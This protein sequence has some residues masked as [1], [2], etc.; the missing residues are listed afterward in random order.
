MEL[1]ISRVISSTLALIF[2]DNLRSCSIIGSTFVPANM[3]TML[4]FFPFALLLV[5]IV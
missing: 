2:A 1:A 3:A 5:I 4:P